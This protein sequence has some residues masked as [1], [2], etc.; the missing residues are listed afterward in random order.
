MT[1]KRFLQI[2]LAIAISTFIALL[3]TLIPFFKDYS[4]WF[5]RQNIDISLILALIFFAMLAFGVSFLSE[6]FKKHRNTLKILTGILSL[7]IFAFVLFPRDQDTNP[8]IGWTILIGLS[9]SSILISVF[10]LLEFTRELA[11]RKVYSVVFA[12]F[13]GIYSC[14]ILSFIFRGYNHSEA[15]IA[16]IIYGL[17]MCLISITVNLI[18]VSSHKNGIRDNS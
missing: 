4:F 9:L 11:I 16:F 18:V 17:I 10:S 13:V 8:I 15:A 3:G 14:S 12:I 1:G 2:R 5:P 6:I 7:M